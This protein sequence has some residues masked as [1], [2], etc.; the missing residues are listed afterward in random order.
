VLEYVARNVAR[1]FI[2]LRGLDELAQLRRRRDDG[3][4]S[5]E[6]YDTE[7]QELAREHARLYERLGL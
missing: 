7:N 3:E 6:Q 5:D 4:L 1:R 2:S